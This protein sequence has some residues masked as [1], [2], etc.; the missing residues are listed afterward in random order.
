MNAAVARTESQRWRGVGVFEF[1]R[2]CVWGGVWV[3]YAQLDAHMHTSPQQQIKH[4]LAVCLPACPASQ[5][6]QFIGVLMKTKRMRLFD[7]GWHLI[8]CREGLK[9]RGV[10]LLTDEMITKARGGG[11][12]S[13]NKSPRFKYFLKSALI[14][15]QMLKHLLYTRDGGKKNPRK[16]GDVLT[17]CF[18][19]GCLIKIC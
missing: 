19:K 9:H 5:L 1:V 3:R 13:T 6:E 15:A 14:L 12:N 8:H 11:G 17:R 4:H 18:M 7:R 2:V 16:T 10:L